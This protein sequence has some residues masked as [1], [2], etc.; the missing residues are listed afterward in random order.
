LTTWDR[1]C[2]RG[3]KKLQGVPKVLIFLEVYYILRWVRTFGASC[4]TNDY[5]LTTGVSLILIV[6]T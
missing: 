1:D 3:K 4:A 5:T 2:C 6:N